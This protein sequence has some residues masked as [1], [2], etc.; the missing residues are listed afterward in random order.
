M[1]AAVASSGRATCRTCRPRPRRAK[2]PEL[3][4]TVSCRLHPA[5]CDQVASVY[6]DHG[7]RGGAGLEEADERQ[8]ALLDGAAE[9][10]RQLGVVDAHLRGA[11]TPVPGVSHP[12]RQH[13]AAVVMIVARTGK[14]CSACRR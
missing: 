13:V 11:A 14:T 4:I 6:H 3:L 5:S 10:Q 9:D 2:W 7:G 1:R 8:G 12:A